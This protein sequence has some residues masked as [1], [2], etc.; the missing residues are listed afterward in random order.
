MNLL[1][2]RASVNYN[3]GEV[4]IYAIRNFRSETFHLLLSQGIGYKP[5]F[6]AILEA[7]RAPKPTRRTIFGELMSRLQ[8]DHLNTSLKH[9]VLEE[10]SDLALAKMLLEAGAEAAH[11]NGL[12]IKHAASN[13][14]RELLRLLSEYSIQSNDVF[15]QAFSAIITRNKQWIAYEHVEVVEIMLQHGASSHVVSKAMAEVV[16]HLACQHAQAGLA[17]TLLRRLFAASADVNHEN[18]KALSTAASRGDP[19]LL[20]LL[21][22]N[23]ATPSS[24]TLALTAAIMAHHEEALLLQLIG[25]FADPRSAIPDFNKSLPG[26][27]PPIFLCLKSYGTSTTILDSLVNAGCQLDTTIPMQVCSLMTEEKRGRTDS[28]ELEPVS[29]LM[30]AV[31]QEE[32]VID[33][34]I[35]KALVR[36][37]GKFNSPDAC[38]VDI[39]PNDHSRRVLHHAQVTNHHTYPR[40]K[41]WTG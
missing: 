20:S 7:L 11:D 6:T 34:A 12:C 10:R 18:G 23:G 38:A 2:N 36:H 37:G 19:F 26:M 33:L 3:N 22:A 15:T 8:L 30:W 40:C 1:L 14:D 17:E 39:G 13:L 21:L 24:A 31:I 25:I 41:I 4:F 27:P 35:V 9:I 28:S 32:G 29:A 16:D 5:L